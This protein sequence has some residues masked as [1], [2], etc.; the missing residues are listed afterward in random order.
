MRK[1]ASFL[2]LAAVNGRGGLPAKQTGCGKDIADSLASCDNG[3]FMIEMPLC[4]LEAKGIHP[5]DLYMS[6]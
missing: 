4:S 3:N 5:A 1:L 2:L 6:K